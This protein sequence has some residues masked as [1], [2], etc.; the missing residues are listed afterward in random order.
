MSMA[1]CPPDRGLRRLF[2]T[3]F[4]EFEV[5][6]EKISFSNRLAPTVK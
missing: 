5:E 6:I 2:C 1:Q 3:F 4:K